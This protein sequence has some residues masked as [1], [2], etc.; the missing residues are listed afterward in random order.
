MI[1]PDRIEDPPGHCR[2]TEIPLTIERNAQSEADWRI[3]RG[4]APHELFTAPK[5]MMIGDQAINMRS[6][7][8]AK[9]EELLAMVESGLV[10]G[11]LPSVGLLFDAHYPEGCL[12][13]LTP[14][15]WRIPQTSAYAPL[16]KPTSPFE[17]AMSVQMIRLFPEVAASPVVLPLV[18][19]AAL[20]SFLGAEDPPPHV[21]LP[22]TPWHTWRSQFQA[23]M[24]GGRKPRRQVGGRPTNP[25]QN[26]A[27]WHEVVRR[28]MAGELAGKTLQ[29]VSQAIH[30]WMSAKFRDTVPEETT[31]RRQLD[32]LFPTTGRV[33][34]GNR[35]GR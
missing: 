12:I 28:A 7:N 21:H 27:M 34:T 3:R 24:A 8:E 5:T 35:S 25:V 11:L 19:E 30:E 1:D 9:Q 29:Q 20:A 26:K 10:N 33:K 16:D 4:P 32:G 31:I 2:L 18:S 23:A 17:W 14:A 15:H 22:I 13:Q 6:P